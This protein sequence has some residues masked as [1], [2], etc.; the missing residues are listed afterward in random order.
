[1]YGLFSGLVK[2][3]EIE[4]QSKQWMRK[5]L[6]LQKNKYKNVTPTTEGLIESAVE[7]FKNPSVLYDRTVPVFKGT[8]RERLADFKA[9]GVKPRVKHRSVNDYTRFDLRGDLRDY[10]GNAVGQKDKNPLIRKKNI[11]EKQISRLDKLL[12]IRSITA[13]G[14]DFLRVYTAPGAY[15]I[16]PHMAD[17]IIGQSANALARD[18]FSKGQLSVKTSPVK[19]K[20]TGE[21]MDEVLVGGPGIPHTAADIT[22][23]QQ[24]ARSGSY[25]DT[26]SRLFETTVIPSQKERFRLKDVYVVDTP[27]A[28]GLFDIADDTRGVAVEELIPTHRDVVFKG[29]KIVTKEQEARNLKDLENIMPSA[30]P[31]QYREVAKS[32]M[33]GD[34]AKVFQTSN[35][36]TKQSPYFYYSPN[37]VVSAHYANR[38]SGV[39]FKSARF[40]KLS[41]DVYRNYLYGKITSKLDDPKLEHLMRTI[42]DR[43]ALY[44]RITNKLPIW[45]Q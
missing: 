30:L 4:K 8:A 36:T 12:R 18:A 25:E 45:L 10:I 16:T 15:G 35:S 27:K 33:S 26:W 43:E 34:L 38:S 19:S 39:P 31:T 3:A 21:V 6:E 37:P 28:R 29:G 41:P 5:L 24:H 42:V 32:G 14:P 7:N 20:V 1:M 13:S 40:L 11:I 44:D 17:D 2:K 23:M 9:R 22:N